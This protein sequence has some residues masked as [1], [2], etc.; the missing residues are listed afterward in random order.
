MKKVVQILLCIFILILPKCN[1]SI[2]QTGAKAENVMAVY[3][4]N[5]TKFFHWPDS[6][7]FDKFFISIYGE[8]NILNPLKIIAG[9]E[10][11]N[12][13]QIVVKELTSLNNLDSCHI[14]FLPN[15]NENQ[16]PDILKLVSGKKILTISNSNGFAENGIGIN[17]L[18]IDQK[19]RFEVNRSAI[20]SVGIVPNSR[21]LS[22]ALKIYNNK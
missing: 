2:A 3:I 7:Q 20:E 13:K 18:S 17:F 9:K 8:S 19:I 21:I 1:S 10:K 5:F 6:N 14:L 22:L 4:Y 12:G 16:L 11:V 15:K